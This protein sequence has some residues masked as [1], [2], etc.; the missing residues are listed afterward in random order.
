MDIPEKLKPIPGFTLNFLPAWVADFGTIDGDDEYPDGMIVMTGKGPDGTLFHV[1]AS[2]KTAVFDETFWERFVHPMVDV[3]GMQ[4]FE[5]EHP[6]LDIQ[7]RRWEWAAAAGELEL[8]QS[9]REVITRR[10]QLMGWK[11][12]ISVLSD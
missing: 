1:D 5:A 4:L 11:P 7:S 12:S 10:D 6:G 8:T 9:Q 3:I 2:P